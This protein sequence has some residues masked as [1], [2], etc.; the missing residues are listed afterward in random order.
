LKSRYWW[1][2]AAVA[3]ASGC[4]KPE[5]IEAV[6]LSQVLKKNQANF[7]TANSIEK[8]FVSNARA[9]SADITANGAGRGVQLDQNATVATELA[10]SA[11]AISVQLGQVRQAV[12]DL[13]LKEEYPQ[14]VRDTLITQLAK[15]QRI[16]QD[17]RASLE[18]SVPEFVEY[19]HSKTYAGDTYP[20]G[21]GELDALLQTYKPP[22]DA[23][24]SALAGLKAKYKLSDTEL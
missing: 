8:D 21:I 1:F 23:V 10:K 17:M 7:A 4:G 5:R 9:W 20:V 19:R 6:Q 14:S 11:V 2:L 22:E 18:K 12:Y 16:L 3:F 13:S 15:R 24:G